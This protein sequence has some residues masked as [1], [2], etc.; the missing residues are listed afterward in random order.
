VIDPKAF[1]AYK[2]KVLKFDSILLAMSNTL[3]IVNMK[4][5][6]THGIL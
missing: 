1:L 3:Q 6:L 2:T 5:D 4:N